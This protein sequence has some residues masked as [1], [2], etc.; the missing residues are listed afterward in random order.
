MA[1]R[2]SRTKPVTVNNVHGAVDMQPTRGLVVLVV[3]S[4]GVVWRSSGRPAA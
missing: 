4:S 3:I 1:A 2:V